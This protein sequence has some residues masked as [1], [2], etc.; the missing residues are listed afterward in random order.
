MFK[1]E[2]KKLNYGQRSKLQTNLFQTRTVYAKNPK[3]KR[4]KMKIS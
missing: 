4:K 2:M 1:N 3:C